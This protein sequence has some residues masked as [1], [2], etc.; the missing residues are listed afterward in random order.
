MNGRT[1][2]YC[3]SFIDPEDHCPACARGP[4]ECVFHEKTRRGPRAAF[5]G[6]L[7]RLRY[8]AEKRRTRPS[9]RRGKCKRTG[10]L[11]GLSKERGA[12]ARPPPR[13]THDRAKNARLPTVYHTC[14]RFDGRAKGRQNPK[15]SSGFYAEIARMSNEIL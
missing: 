2:R 14:R 11:P 4:N 8:W 1:C 6:K 5:C 15:P 12:V 3:G 7:C 10:G 13:P 9:A